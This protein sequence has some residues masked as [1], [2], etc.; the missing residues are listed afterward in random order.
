MTVAWSAFWA[1]R[2]LLYVACFSIVQQKNKC[3]NARCEKK[4]GT[5]YA[6]TSRVS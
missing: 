6:Y 5:R 3:Y 2:S 4:F 1:D